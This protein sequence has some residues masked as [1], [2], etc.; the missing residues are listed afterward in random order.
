[1]ASNATNSNPGRM[2]R[3]FD[4]LFP[5]RKHFAIT[6]AVE[7]ALAALGP[8]RGLVSY[9]VHWPTS[10][11]SDWRGS[12]SHATRADVTREPYAMPALDIERI[13]ST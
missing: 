12:R 11:P 6:I 7:M 2:A 3:A 9:W 10:S 1:M 5:S 13:P 8:R 4:W